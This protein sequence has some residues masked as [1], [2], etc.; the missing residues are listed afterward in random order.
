MSMNPTPSRDENSFNAHLP[1]SLPLTRRATLRSRETSTPTLK[2]R[3]PGVTP[4]P[5]TTTPG[6]GGF[7]LALAGMLLKRKPQ[8][9]PPLQTTF[10]GS[11]SLHPAVLQSQRHT[12]AGSFVGST[13]VKDDVAVPRQPFVGSVYL[14]QRHHSGP[15]YNHPLPLDLGGMSKVG[16]HDFF[17]TVQHLF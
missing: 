6:S 10:Q 17:P 9:S 4:S 2:N 16:D 1:F 13:T 5:P 7:L 15:R 3:Q 14:I 11:D 12:G 8:L